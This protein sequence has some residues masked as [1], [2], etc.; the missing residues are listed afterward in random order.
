M[1]LQSYLRDI[2]MFLC[3]V[4]CEGMTLMVAGFIF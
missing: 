1:N 2:L 3:D 4:M